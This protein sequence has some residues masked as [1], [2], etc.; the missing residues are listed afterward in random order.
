MKNKVLAIIGGTVALFGL[1]YL[2]YCIFQLRGHTEVACE[3]MNVSAI[4]LMEVLYATFLVVIFGRWAQIK[5]FAAGAQ[6]GFV[7]G[8]FVGVCAQLELFATSDVTTINGIL[9]TLVTFGVRFAVAGG[10]VGWLLGRD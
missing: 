8:A 9:L 6:A 3:S 2:I 1:G 4:I 7:I 10:I 5:T